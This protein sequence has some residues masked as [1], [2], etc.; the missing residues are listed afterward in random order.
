MH[1]P[2]HFP[3]ASGPHLLRDGRAPASAVGRVLVACALA[4]LLW[5]AALAEAS[6]QQFV[7]DDAGTVGFRACQLEGWYGESASWILPACE[8]V[9]N[10]EITAGVGFLPENGTHDTEYVLQGKYLL[11]QLTTGDIGVGV[12]A[13]LGFGPLSQV[14]GNGVAGVFAYVPVGLS[15]VADR[16]ILHAN[17]G[18]HFDRNDHDDHAHEQAERHHALAWAARA[19][20]LLPVPGERVTLI[21]ELFGQ[22]RVRPEYQVGL[23]T[24][25]IP[26]RLDFDLSWG[27]HTAAALPGAGWAAGVAWTPPPFF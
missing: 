11:R 16:L 15:L 17:L 7:T 20:V 25:I 4:P 22:N 3:I 10:L 18:W 6:A 26:D 14:V 9:R 1:S 13:G 23:R 19:D 2:T 12:V 21:G 5:L 24:T 27:G 8:F